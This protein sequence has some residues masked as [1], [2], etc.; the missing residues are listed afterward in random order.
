[1]KFVPHGIGKERQTVTYQTVKD[2][3]IQL[4]QKSFRNGKDVADS[5]RKMEKINMTKHMLIRKISQDTGTDKV[6]EQEGFDML[7]KAEIDI[8]TKRRHEFEDNM[9]KTYSL[10]F[11]Q[12]CNKTI[13]DR[14]LGHPKFEDKIENDPIELLKAVEILI[15]DPVRARYPYASITESITRFRTCKQLENESLTDYVKRLKS[16]TGANNGQGFLEEIRRNTQGNTRM[17]QTWTSKTPCTKQP[18]QDGRHIC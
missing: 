5:L 15:N 7:Y 1:M 10:I 9:N 6:T 8:Y 14:I 17:N 11:L 18:I 12:H 16:N 2:Y 13:Q 3:I 4:V